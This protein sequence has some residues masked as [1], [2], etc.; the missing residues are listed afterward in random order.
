MWRVVI[1]TNEA[2]GRN[3]SPE[4]YLHGIC[5][6]LNKKSWECSEESIPIIQFKCLT[7]ILHGDLRWR[8]LLHSNELKPPVDNRVVLVNLH[9]VWVAEGGGLIDQLLD[10]VTHAVCK[11]SVGN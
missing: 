10:D 6:T 9:P 3:G 2:G 1:P 5:G 11:E 8:M 4:S 7:S